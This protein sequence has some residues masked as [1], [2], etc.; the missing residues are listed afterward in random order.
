MIIDPFTATA[1]T[2]GI[3]SIFSGIGGQAEADAQNRAIEAQYLQLSR[4]C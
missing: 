3:S 4:F 1:I 2:G